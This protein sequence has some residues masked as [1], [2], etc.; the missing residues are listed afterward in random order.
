MEDV[1]A[2]LDEYVDEVNQIGDV[3]AQDMSFGND[4]DEVRLASETATQHSVVEYLSFPFWC[5]LVVAKRSPYAT[6]ALCFSRSLHAILTHPLCTSQSELEEE[7]MG[8]EDELNAEALDSFESQ[9]LGPDPTGRSC[10]G[11]A[12]VHDVHC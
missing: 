3:L 9:L 5:F 1:L 8:M 10:V 6:T 4:I 2:D 7:L 12:H 11:A